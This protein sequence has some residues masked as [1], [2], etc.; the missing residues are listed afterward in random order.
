MIIN[1]GPEGERHDCRIET[2]QGAECV[3]YV[4]GGGWVGGSYEN[5]NLA[6]I[7]DDPTKIVAAMNYTLATDDKKS[8]GGVL[9]DVQRCINKIRGDYNPAS[10]T[11]VG[12][13][14]GANIALYSTLYFKGLNN[15]GHVPA[16]RLKLFYGYYDPKR[17]EDLRP[18]VLD[19]YHKHLGV[20][21]EIPEIQAAERDR[22]NMM[23]KLDRL[24]GMRV[25]LFH[26]AVDPLINVEQSRR[27]YAFLKGIC[28][29]SYTEIYAGHG[30]K[31]AD[32]V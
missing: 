3:L 19:M 16:D 23:S 1:Y 9:G 26:G 4:H 8:F 22:V 7:W 12:T 17:P 5:R 28:N 15:P 31:V 13:S 30:F 6:G 25:E 11:L 10:L 14:A 32:W 18:D 29:V 24:E 2:L 27:L 20:Y 21:G